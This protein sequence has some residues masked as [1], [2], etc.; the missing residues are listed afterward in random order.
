MSRQSPVRIRTLTPPPT[1]RSRGARASSQ[2]GPRPTGRVGAPGDGGAGRAGDAARERRISWPHP[3]R[4]HPKPEA[5][6]AEPGP[7]VGEGGAETPTLGTGTEVVGGHVV[8]V[9][10]W[11]VGRR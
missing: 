9:R 8:G 1:P 5:P 10:A 7:A 4:D 3:S 2:A 6:G 11:D